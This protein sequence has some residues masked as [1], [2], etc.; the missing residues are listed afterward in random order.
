MNRD[1]RQR[2]YTIFIIYKEENK[3]KIENYGIGIR[4]SQTVE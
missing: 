4:T 3:I 1:E 2:S